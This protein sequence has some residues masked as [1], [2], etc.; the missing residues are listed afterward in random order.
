MSDIAKVSTE[1][2]PSAVTQI[3]GIRAVTLTATPD[4]EDLGALTQ[5][6]QSRLDGSTCRPG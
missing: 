1:Q 2:T 6:V 4:V 3:D 5:T